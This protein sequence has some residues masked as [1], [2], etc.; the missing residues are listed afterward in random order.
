MGVTTKM[1]TVIRTEVAVATCAN[2]SATD[3][4]DD[5]ELIAFMELAALI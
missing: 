2:E 5:V 3:A 1:V 4:E